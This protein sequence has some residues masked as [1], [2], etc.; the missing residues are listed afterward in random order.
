MC[1]AATKT[2][3]RDEET[4]GARAEEERAGGE[5]TCG[6]DGEETQRRGGAQEGRRG[7]EEGGPRAGELTLTL[8]SSL[9]MA[10]VF[11][12]GP[13]TSA[14]SSRAFVAQDEM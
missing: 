14:N 4:T 6:G 9:I 8:T 7:E 10:L 5:E 13:S 3:A 12:V 1:T 2:R 11:S